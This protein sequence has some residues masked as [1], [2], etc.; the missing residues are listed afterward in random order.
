VRNLGGKGRVSGG[1]AWQ[2]ENI[3][4]YIPIYVWNFLFL[5]FNKAV[6]VLDGLWDN[7]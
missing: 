7:I 3:Y 2:L 5:S 6:L 4:I 1:W